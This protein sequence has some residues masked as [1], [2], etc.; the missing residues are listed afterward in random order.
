MQSSHASYSLNSTC[1]SSGLALSDSPSHHPISAV[2]A[3]QCTHLARYPP[4]T[5]LPGAKLTVPPARVAEHPGQGSRTAK[6]R[7]LPCRC[8]QHGQQVAVCVVP[9]GFHCSNVVS[10]HFADALLNQAEEQEAAQGS[11]QHHASQLG[12]AVA[13]GGKV[14][15]KE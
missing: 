2:P 10:S 15:R 13:S 8:L 12:T 14:K 11:H 1:P 4:C 7:A 6:G 9:G 3:A 5:C